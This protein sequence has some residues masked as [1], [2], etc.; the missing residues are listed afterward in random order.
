MPYV[1]DWDW[2]VT[3]LFDGVGNLVPR[4]KEKVEELMIDFAVTAV[5][6]MKANAPWTDD[7]GSA[8]EGLDAKVDNKD[9]T[10]SIDL[11]HTVDYGIWLEIRWGGTYAIILPTIETMGPQLMQQFKDI[12]SEIDFT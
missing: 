2:G 3:T 9:G 1:I 8:R 10:I 7:T 11:F 4:T 6:Y 12:I 5:D